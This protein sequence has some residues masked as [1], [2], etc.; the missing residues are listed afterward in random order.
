MMHRLLNQCC[1]DIT[2]ENQDVMLK[3]VYDGRFGF[4]LDER[5]GSAGFLGAILLGTTVGFLTG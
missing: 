1:T 3:K 5:N 4:G 2:P